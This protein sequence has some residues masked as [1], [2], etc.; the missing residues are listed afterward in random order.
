[1]LVSSKRESRISKESHAYTT[2]RSSGSL[3]PPR[4][5][6]KLE[7][8]V[9]NS[10]QHSPGSAKV[11][12]RGRKRKSSKQ[13][14]ASDDDDNS[15]EVKSEQE[16]EEEDVDERMVE[17]S[18]SE[19]YH[20]QPPRPPQEPASDQE[21]EEEGTP[22]SP[23]PAQSPAYVQQDTAEE[24]TPTVSPLSQPQHETERR[25]DSLPTVPASSSSKPDPPNKKR[26]RP[27]SFSSSSATTESHT[28]TKHP[29][30]SQVAR[31]R[32]TSRPKKRMKTTTV[33]KQKWEELNDFQSQ[34]VTDLGM[35]PGHD[36]GERGIS[37]K[38]PELD[39]ADMDLDCS[40]VE[41]LH[42]PSP[43]MSVPDQAP[44]SRAESAAGSE[45]HS[46]SGRVTKSIPPPNSR[47]KEVGSPGRSATSSTRLPSTPLR[48]GSD[49]ND[50]D[51][52]QRSP[53]LLSPRAKKRLEIFDRAMME[54]ELRKKEEEEQQPEDDEVKS[55]EGNEE[56]GEGE[57]EGEEEDGEMVVAEGGRQEPG[58]VR[59]SEKSWK[60]KNKEQKKEDKTRTPTLKP[61]EIKKRK[62]V[63]T[64]DESDSEDK[65]ALRPKNSV[66]RS[67]NVE[68][69]LAVESSDIDI[70]TQTSTGIVEQQLDPMHLRQEEEESTQ[71]LMAELLLHQQQQ[72]IG[73][74]QSGALVPEIINDTGDLPA[75]QID[76]QPI[77]E[78][79]LDMGVQN[80]GAANI[81]KS[82]RFL[83]E[84][85]NVCIIFI[86]H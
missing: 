75:S 43:E 10:R 23:V 56:E 38:L 22:T 20:S 26:T 83:D 13:V 45:S 44:R 35:V 81:E 1:M 55:R 7:V 64:S 48:K 66:G 60:G 68:A 2:G 59:T 46:L 29:I 76:S 58:F 72:G 37:E 34:Q 39:S 40:A 8:E 71:D 12:N 36:K 69:D 14:T 5:K 33:S 51:H 41:E 79:M 25:I 78:A 67:Q 65:P 62:K 63:E 18:L 80:R 49:A 70:D 32:P 3:P 86:F 77:S 57:E 27:S 28:T 24:S 50:E 4:K 6:R 73:V 54:I 17:E 53:I 11:N 19:V 85:P 16:E 15:K 61:P 74:G 52:S 84:I 82:D 30:L 9:V 31:P 47:S 21:E 42:P